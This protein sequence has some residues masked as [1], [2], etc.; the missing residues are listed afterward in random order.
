VGR[1][2]PLADRRQ[3]AV[4]RVLGG[5]ADLVVTV[6]EPIADRFREWG[7]PRVAVVRNTFPGLAR[8]PI[9]RPA[10]AGLLYAGRIGEG[11]DLPAVLA[12]AADDGQAPGGAPLRWTLMGTRDE[13]FLA[14]RQ[15]PAGVELR[16]ATAVDDVDDALRDEGLALVTLEDSCENHR[17]ALP[18]KLFHA[19]R[20]GVPVVAADL[21]AM[22]GVVRRHGI[23]VLYRPGD[24]ASLAAAARE[25]VARYPEL[26]AAVTAVQADGA[27]SWDHDA[28]VL[29]AAYAEL[30]ERRGATG[31]H[32]NGR[33]AGTVPQPGRTA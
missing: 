9:A 11:R 5:R 27:L 10:P 15:L 31:R 20:A 23:G 1:P 25:A 3:I 16:P 17:L 12:A 14:G 2:T 8:E 18:N 29:P 13:T 19:V 6:S 30:Q 28:A 24:A 33:A 32:G 22:A 26:L 7:W 4:E 21:P